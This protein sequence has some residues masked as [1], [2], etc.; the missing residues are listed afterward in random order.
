[1]EYIN[2]VENNII[3]KIKKLKMKKHRE[4][5]KLFLAE[6]V[7]FLDYSYEPEIIVLREEFEKNREIQEKVLKFNSRKIVVPEKIFNQLSTQEN[8]QGV[9]LAYPYCNSNVNELKNNVVVLDKIQ[10]PGNLGTIIRVTDAAGFKDIILSKGSVDVYNE[11]CVRSSMGSIFNMNIIYLTESE[12]LKF[13]I[14]NNYKLH[15]TAL[16]KN[17]INYTDITLERK[18]A[19]IFGNEGNGISLP[20]LNAVE[21]TVYIPIFGSAESLNVAIASGIVLYKVRE[22]LDK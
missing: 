22:L 20:F 3:K 2:S 12:I 14:S 7:K 18:N 11:K 19:I 8:S 6:G 10:D 17:S 15:V 4:E 16:E 1:M 13:L 21:K 9:I 5:E